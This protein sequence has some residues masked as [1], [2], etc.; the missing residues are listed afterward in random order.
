MEVAAP[1]AG[2]FMRCRSNGMSSRWTVAGSS[3]PNDVLTIP[4]CTTFAVTTA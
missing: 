1:W 2:V 3:A 4:G